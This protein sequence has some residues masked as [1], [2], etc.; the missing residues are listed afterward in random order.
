MKAVVFHDT[1][2]IR[3]DTVLDPT[4]KAPTD[5]IVRLT[6]SAIC[7]TDLHF[8]RGTFGGMTAGTIL[9]H[10]GVGIVEEVGSGVRNLRRGDRVVVPSTIA[11]G[12][13]SYCRTGYTAQCDD[14][15]PN[16]P[17]AGTAF[18]GG[19]AP[20]GPFDGLQAEF[21]RIPFA[22]HNLVRLPRDVTDDQAILLSDIY[23]TAWFGAECA[24]VGDG[25]VVAVWGCG[26]VGLFAVLSAFQKGAHRVIA[27]DGHDDRL[28]RARLLGAETVNFNREDPVAVIKELTRGIGV[29]RAI[30]AVGVD[31]EMPKEGPAAEQA[32]TMAEQFRQEVEKVAPGAKPQGGQWKPGD[33]PSQALTWAVEAL[34]KAGT[35][36]IIGVYPP[37]D[38]VF[39]IGAAMNKN[40]TINMGNCNHRTYIPKLLEMVDGGTVD[41]TVVL[42]HVEPMSDVVEAYKQF[43]LRRPGWIKVELRP[44]R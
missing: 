36:G 4:I 30:D 5:A 23:P 26:P 6:A 25:D 17:S 31:S 18:Y 33:A 28:E 8:V 12:N 42:S 35:L 15:N 7:G 41:P 22:Y 16:G 14:A 19:P 34:A 2:D 38:S 10:E 21:A 3:L 37:T 40:L 9:G 44:G 32:K 11:C 39:P 24:E 29:D 20:T 43:D 13:C 27:V 1:A